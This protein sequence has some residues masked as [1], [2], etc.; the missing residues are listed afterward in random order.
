MRS[1]TPCCSAVSSSAA[2]D[3][4]G[5]RRS[6]TKSAMVKSVSWPTAETTGI[7]EAA[8]AR[9]SVSE[10]KGAR[11]S[12]EPPPRAMTTA[13]TFFAR[14]NQAMPEAISPAACSPCTVAG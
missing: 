4:V 5:A 11:S 14:L 7:S 12:G 1:F 10:L 2:A 3:G 8:M 6:A 13:S 9:A